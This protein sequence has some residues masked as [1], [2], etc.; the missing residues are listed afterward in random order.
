MITTLAIGIPVA[1]LL[2]CNFLFWAFSPNAGWKD[3]ARINGLWV[4]CLTVGGVIPVMIHLTDSIILAST[5]TFSIW[6]VVIGI[7]ARWIRNTN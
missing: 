3:Y 7:G 4:V 2:A 6:V 1:V 5:V